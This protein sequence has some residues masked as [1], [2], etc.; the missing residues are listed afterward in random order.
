LISRRLHHNLDMTHATI[1][2]VLMTAAMLLVSLAKT[3]YWDPW[4]RRRPGRAA[5]RMPP[6]PTLV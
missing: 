1:G 2:F 4:R 6:R 5:R 3:K